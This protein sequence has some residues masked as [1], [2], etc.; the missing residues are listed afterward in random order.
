M[1]Y[2]S[3][4][5]ENKQAEIV[6]IPYGKC[7][8][9][10]TIRSEIICQKACP[11]Y[12][13]DFIIDTGCTVSCISQQF[14]NQ[15]PID[16]PILGEKE[17]H[18]SGGKIFESIASIWRIYL[19]G[20]ILWEDPNIGLDRYSFDVSSVAD[21]NRSIPVVGLLGMD[22]L[23]HFDFSFKETGYLELRKIREFDSKD[24]VYKVRKKHILD[25]EESITRLSK[26]AATIQSF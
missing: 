16:L 3:E 20:V 8:G 2:L 9:L 15:C 22:F 21:D 11:K 7:E 5:K 23:S 12:L 6:A 24:S 10:Y 1:D 17:V 13:M 4:G 18:T 25:Q 26:T 14:L 19:G